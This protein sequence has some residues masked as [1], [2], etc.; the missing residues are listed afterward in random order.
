MEAIS[1]MGV[2]A[3]LGIALAVSISVACVC[4][5]VMWWKGMVKVD[6]HVTV[7]VKGRNDGQ[8]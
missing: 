6:F 7:E 4:L 5:L 2:N 3:L 1:A 8:D